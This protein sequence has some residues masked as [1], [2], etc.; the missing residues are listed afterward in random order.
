MQEAW[1]GEQDGVLRDDGAIVFEEFEEGDPRRGP[2]S[3]SVQNEAD[4][5]ARLPGRWHLQKR[6]VDWFAIRL[7]VGRGY[8]MQRVGHVFGVGD[9]HI[10]SRAKREKWVAPMA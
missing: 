8:A 5:Q 6:H 7:M 1:M 4:A 9:S 2:H 3:L 10:S